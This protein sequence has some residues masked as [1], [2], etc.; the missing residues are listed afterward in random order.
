[1]ILIKISWNVRNVGLILFSTLVHRSLTPNRGTPDL[2]QNR[3]TL[4]K[5]QTLF[6]WHNTHPSIIPYLRDILG[7]SS[8]AGS[9]GAANSHSPI[10]PILI[11]LRSLR[12]SSEGGSLA[13]G[14]KTVV[15]PYLGS[16]ERQVSGCV[17]FWLLANTTRYERW[18][19]KR[20]RPSCHLTKL[21]GNLLPFPLRVLLRIVSMAIYCFHATSSQTLSTGP[22][23]QPSRGG[24]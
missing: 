21:F 19:H 5:R 9:T 14:L 18:Q 22:T 4:S 1:V 17:C 13:A 12:W 7:D 10:F 2:F 3:T 24:S 11:I 23:W 16:P 20:I 15:L 6:N 8:S